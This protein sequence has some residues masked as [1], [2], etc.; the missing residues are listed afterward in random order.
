MNKKVVLAYSGGLDTSYCLKYLT[1]E[2]NLD[3]Y[4]VIANTG[5]FSK[6]ELEDIEN[7]AYALGSIKHT[8]LDVTDEYYQKCIKYMVYGNILKNNTYPISV[9]SERVFQAIAIIKYAKKINA[10]Y[11]AHGST[12]AGNDQIRFDMTFN[13]LAPDI[14]ILTPTRDEKLTREYEINYLKKHG[15]NY[16]E[17]QCQYSINKGLWGTSIGGK[18]TLCSSKTLPEEAYPS[19]LEKKGSEELCLH[20][21]KGELKGVNGKNFKNPVEAILE[22]ES[23]A[24]KYAIGRD[25]HIG[26]T[27]I[28]IKGRVAFEAAAPIVI[29]KAHHMLEKHTLG[30]W[31]QHWKEQLA[32]WYG[33]FL[34][35]SMY[36]DPVMKNIEAFLEDSQ[37]T[38]SG[39]VCLKLMP[40][41][42]Q[43]IGIESEHDLMNSNF[44]EYG[45]L[46]NAWTH[47]DVKGF[48]KIAGMHLKLYN[49]VNG[50]NL[51]DND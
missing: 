12:G 42:F 40:Y 51:I 41:T 37:K 20:F 16:I 39:N 35:E 49:S 43:M 27:I 13:V 9:S 34:H 47:E 18:E 8:S 2:K 17:N 3:V 21:V 25:M 44:G 30:K 36:M 14:E 24:S 38:V 26:D 19:Q 7:K 6:K 28:G 15:F 1:E 33:M 23:I 10:D 46:N 45:E 32:N 31:Q 29:I 11:V 50:L 48:S 4:T 22:V 5:G